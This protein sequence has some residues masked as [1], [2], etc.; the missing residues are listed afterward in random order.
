[1]SNGGH[2]IKNLSTLSERSESKGTN[3]WGGS[4]ASPFDSLAFAPLHEGRGS[5]EQDTRLL[6]TGVEWGKH[7]A[8]C[9]YKVIKLLH[10]LYLS[11]FN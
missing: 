10:R 1:M 11:R 8:L 6:S 4:G 7:Q 9:V 2:N 5:R 3:F